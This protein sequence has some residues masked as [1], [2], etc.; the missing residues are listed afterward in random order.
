LGLDVIVIGGGIGGLCLAQGLRKAGVSVVVYEKGPRRADPR[1]LQGYQIHIDPN[2]AKALKDCLPPAIWG[3][4]V[5]NAYQPS[6][7]FQVLTEKMKQI[8]FVE[9]EIMNGSSHVPIDR[10]TL[11]EMLL[12]GL[13]KVVHFDKEFVC[14]EQAR[15]GKIKALFEHGSSAIGDVL[16]GADGT[17]SKVCK[18]YLPQ[19]HIVDTGVVGAACRLPFNSGDRGYLPEHLL[20][21]LTSIVARRGYMVVTQSIHKPGSHLSTDTIGDHIIWVFV[22]SRQAYGD[23][24]PRFMDGGSVK[25]LVL[26][27][28]EHWHPALRQIVADSDSEQVSAVPILT[29]VPI[30]R[31]ETT[32]VTLLGDAIHTMTPLQG[33][34]GSSALRDAGLL[35]HKLVDIDRGR[36]F[37][38]PAIREY[39]T[40]MVKYGF[41]AVRL[42]RRF[43][44]LVMSDNCLLRAAFKAALRVTNMVPPLKRLMF[45]PGR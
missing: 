4:L 45:R 22:S 6:A 33:L 13:D 42:S 37:L 3:A 16:V 24:N 20:T 29:S 2:G 7:G 23:A 17:G 31:W 30:G 43:A 41:D 11:R 40:A 14:Y 36:S 9:P 15:E 35:C 21:R 25:S 27:R 38:I 39:E 10:A 44:D 8:A 19:A 32:S 5:A 34:G 26:Q 28:I 18:Q 1:W 12:E